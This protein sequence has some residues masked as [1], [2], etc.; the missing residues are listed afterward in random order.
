MSM[1]CI[2]LSLVYLISESSSASVGIQACLL[3]RYVF[4]K[5]LHCSHIIF[6]KEST[7]VSRVCVPDALAISNGKQIVM[8]SSLV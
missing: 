8:L 3:H 1:L 4:C 2:C 5:C 7:L 6:N